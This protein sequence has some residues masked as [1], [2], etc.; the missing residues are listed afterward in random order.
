MIDFSRYLT[1]NH[2]ITV[3]KSSKERQITMTKTKSKSRK[4]YRYR[5]N[6]AAIVL[7]NLF[8]ITLVCA[9]AYLFYTEAGSDVFLSGTTLNGYDVSE[10][11]AQ[12][13]M[14]LLL[15]NYDGSSLE[16]TEGGET[17]F[18]ASLSDIGCRVDESQLLSNIQDYLDNQRM[19]LLVNF[20]TSNSSQAE[21]PFTVDETVFNEAVT[22]AKLSKERIASVDSEMIFK[23]GSYEITPA[24]YGNEFED[25][26]LQAL[27][28]DALSEA[29]FS[30]NSLTVKVD[31]PSSVYDSPSVTEDDAEL[32]RLMNIY[33][34]YCKASITYLFGDEKVV[35]DWDTIQNWLIIDGDTADIDETQAADFVYNLAV[36][37][38]T[39]YAN[40][41]FT[42]SSGNTVTMT[43][44]DYGYLIDQDGELSQ[45]LANIR[46]NLTE[47]REPLYSERGFSRNGTDDLNGNYVEV[48]LTRQHLWFYR[49]G[50]LVVE[51]DIVSGLPTE[52]RETATGVFAIAYKASPYNL[53]GGGSEEGSTDGWDVEVQYWMPF[54]DGQGLHDASWRGSFGGS[55]YQ[56]GGS[57]GCVN[58][59]TAAAAA[60]YESMEAGIPIVLYKS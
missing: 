37:Y 18:A 55:I 5:R 2:F 50:S 41:T 19:Q 8:L 1:Y 42:G 20:F 38:N 13:A 30:G 57:H 26:V 33:N 51:T 52:E 59:P 35:L 14:A 23:D 28:R 54:H 36:K 56:S 10:K 27:V 53:V 31:I 16:I 44:S 6:K 7:V 4:K 58:L 40:R 60:I 29:D 9:G 3:F 25:S 24:V 39:R 45:L 17:V 47:E 12:E 21:I 32:N 22:V 43:S 15:Q 48:D 49:N 11:T 46:A 34:Q